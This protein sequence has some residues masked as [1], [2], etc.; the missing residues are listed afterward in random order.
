MLSFKS[1]IPIA[2]AYD[3]KKKYIIY[4]NEDAEPIDCKYT[5]DRVERNMLLDTLNIDVDEYNKI[6][7]HMC[8]NDPPIQFPSKL[9]KK[10]IKIQEKLHDKKNREL[11]FSK[12]DIKLEPIIFSDSKFFGHSV[13]ISAT[14][15]GKTYFCSKLLQNQT[16]N[17]QV[18]IFGS[19]AITDPS[20]KNLK[21]RKNVLFWPL[22]TKSMEDSI[23]FSLPTISAI[24]PDSILVFDDIQSLPRKLKFKNIDHHLNNYNLKKHMWNL[25]NDIIEIARHDNICI[26]N[27]SHIL[28]N[29]MQNKSI[30]NES[31]HF[32]LYPRSNRSVVSNFLFDQ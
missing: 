30:R 20:F 1:G 2:N 28:K 21:N 10:Y 18:V 3:G 9:K 15:A 22:S 27:I 17:R 6:M 12:T 5:F 13:F 23:K 8:Q 26:V 11:D 4:Y 25:V 14:G 16:K 24:P 19:V 29:G 7:S 32:I 31:K